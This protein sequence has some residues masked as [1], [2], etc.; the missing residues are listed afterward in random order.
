MKK[1]N[2]IIGATA[3]TAASAANA[4]LVQITLAGNILSSSAGN[5]LQTDL[6]GDLVDDVSFTNSNSTIA[7]S[8]IQVNIQS[9]NSATGYARAGV[10]P[11][12][13]TGNSFVAQAISETETVPSLFGSANSTG[14]FSITFTDASYGGTVNAFLEITSSS[15]T[16]GQTIS[17]NRLIFD[18]EN[19][20]A[21]PD[22]TGVNL[23]LTTF[24]EAVQIPEPSS[25]ALLAL[26]AT[27]L[28]TR[29]RRNQTS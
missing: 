6:T 14:L 23:G 19:L 16:S 13:F 22:L 26:G 8:F 10:Q 5:N 18:N 17:L 20:T 11:S 1:Q 9:M 7:P 29:R 21:E 28:I 25:L 3:L 2:L 27:G 24:D 15:S 12:T 4:S